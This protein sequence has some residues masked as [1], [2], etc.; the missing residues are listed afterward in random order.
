[1][2]LA[3]RIAAI[4]GSLSISRHPFVPPLPGAGDGNIL[5]PAVPWCPASA[6]RQ[7][8]HVRLYS[9]GIAHGWE[10]NNLQRARI[11]ALTVAVLSHRRVQ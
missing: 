2:R 10:G 9:A 11:A 3:M 1:M 7:T 6:A 4:T 5:I 8:L